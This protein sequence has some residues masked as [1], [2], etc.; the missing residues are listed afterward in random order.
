[1]CSIKEKK[2]NQKRA[3]KHQKWSFLDTFFWAPGAPIFKEKG[4]MKKR[5]SVKNHIFFVFF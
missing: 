2:K 4:K 1:V 5:F 3:Q